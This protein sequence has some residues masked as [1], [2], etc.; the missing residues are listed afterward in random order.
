MSE[1]DSSA[2]DI[3]NTPPTFGQAAA[4]LDGNR[5]IVTVDVR[6]DHSPIQQVEYSS[7]G[8]V[9]QA[10]FPTDGIADSLTERYELVIDGRIGPRGITLRAVDSMNNASTTQI[11]AQ[12]AR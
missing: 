4:R 8:E 11:D 6:D 7:D 10:V 3:D 1:L 5:T 9:W 2:F 12:A